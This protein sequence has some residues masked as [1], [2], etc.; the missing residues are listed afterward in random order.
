MNIP[1]VIRVYGKAKVAYVKG[2]RVERQSQIFVPSYHE[3]YR[4]IEEDDLHFC[5]YNKRELGSTMMCTC[6][7]TA[8]IYRFDVYRRFTSINRGQ[9]IAC[10]HYMETGIHADGSGRR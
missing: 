1:K 6:G 7:S 3:W 5:Y 10:T 4:T 9:V 2:E 8:G